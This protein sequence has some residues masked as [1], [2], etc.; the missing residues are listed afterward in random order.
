[1]PY[2]SNAWR[3]VSDWRWIPGCRTAGLAYMA[4]RD[5]SGWG[6]CKA[7]A[8]LRSDCWLVW[9]DR[10]RTPPRNRISG[11]RRDFEQTKE[12]MRQLGEEAKEYLNPA[13]L[14]AG[15][16]S[17]LAKLLHTAG[18]AMTALAAQAEGALVDQT[19]DITMGRPPPGSG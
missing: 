5:S 3:K 15:A 7:V 6:Y 4:H 13:R 16:L 12:E 11:R 14:G 1:M 19:G 17:S 10:L 2:K 8:S 9:R 18:G